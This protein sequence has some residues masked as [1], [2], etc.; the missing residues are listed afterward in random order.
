[1]GP[2]FSTENSDHKKGQGESCFKVRWK[3]H[4]LEKKHDF[5]R[6]N[7]PEE[8]KNYK[9]VFFFFFWLLYLFFN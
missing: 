8:Q 2:V 1:M 7:F 9:N 5:L 4:N 6:K 3:P